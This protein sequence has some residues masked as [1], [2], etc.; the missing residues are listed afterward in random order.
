M[1]ER[2]FELRLTSSYT[3]PDNTPTKLTVEHYADGQWSDFD[4]GYHSPGFLIFVYALFSCQHTYL[5]LN[6]AEKGIK[7]A[8]T[9]G[10]I[11]VVTDE[12]WDLTEM[13]VRF[14]VKTIEGRASSD[15]IT[16]I[17]Q[18]MEQ[19]P[20]SRNIKHPQKLST[21]LDFTRV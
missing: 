13:T 21:K 17:A 12:N 7:L 5:R 15:D 14:D 9:H 4:L 19:C 18:R 16:H 11:R 2:I 20:A 8:T 10:Q 1:S 6:C 3:A